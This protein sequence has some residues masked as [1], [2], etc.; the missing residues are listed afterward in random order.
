MINPI[1]RNCNSVKSVSHGIFCLSF[2]LI[3]FSI[4]PHHLH[5]IN[6][7]SFVLTCAEI[8]DPCPFSFSLCLLKSIKW[9]LQVRTALSHQNIRP[10]FFDMMST[11][12]PKI[13]FYKN[14][15]HKWHPFSTFVCFGEHLVRLNE[16]KLSSHNKCLLD[17]CHFERP[18][19][20]Q[21]EQINLISHVYLLSH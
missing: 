20:P 21:G 2:Q 5:L 9:S 10:G 15:K 11:L 19:V 3:L 6:K 18:Y 4:H 1:L 14:F 16:Y 12:C 7:C 13:W 8:S 17:V